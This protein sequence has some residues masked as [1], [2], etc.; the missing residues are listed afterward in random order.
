MVSPPTKATEQGTATAN[1]ASLNA[2]SQAS[3]ASGT[4]SASVAQ[5]GCAPAAAS[6]LRAVAMTSLPRRAGSCARA[7]W[8]APAGVDGDA[9]HQVFA[10][11]E[12]QHRAVVADAHQHVVAHGQRA[13]E[14]A[15][16]E[17]ELAEGHAGSAG[18]P[19]A[20]AT[21][22]LYAR[23]PPALDSRRAATSTMAI[24]RLC[25]RR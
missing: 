9:G 5:A 1:S 24:R 12:P 14:E 7:C 21:A 13:G 19:A 4:V 11:A 16:D 25:T 6:R 8:A 17:G 22:P 18:Q 20:A 15:I 3:S 23:R 10:G 2:P